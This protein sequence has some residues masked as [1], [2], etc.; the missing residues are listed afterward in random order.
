[1]LDIHQRARN[2]ARQN[3]EVSWLP[4]MNLLVRRTTFVLI[5]GF[6]ETLATAEE[7]DLC[8]DFRIMEKF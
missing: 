2:I 5:G 1:M 4:S 7:V 8:S 6:S 3:A